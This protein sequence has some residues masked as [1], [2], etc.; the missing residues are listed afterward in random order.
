MTLL[1]AAWLAAALS[2]CALKPVSRAD[3]AM[4][5]IVSFTVYGGSEE[6]LDECVALC[7][8]YEGLW[9]RTIETSDIFRLNDAGGEPVA[10]SPDTAELIANAKRYCADSGG[11]LDVTIGGVSALWDFNKQV[12][13]EK[14]EILKRLPSVDYRNIGVEG[15]TVTL[16]NGAELDLG[17]VAKGTVADKLAVFLRER[18]IKSAIINLGGNVYALGCR[19][20][21]KPF[22]V[23]IRSPFDENELLGTIGL[24]DTS[25]VTSGVYER[26]FVKDGR[27]YHHL[28][29]PKTGFPV[30]NGLVSV[31]IIDKT[32]EKAD[33]LSTACF[34]LGLTD[35]MALARKEGVE[36]IFVTSDGSLH[37]TGG[38][39]ALGFKKAGGNGN[40]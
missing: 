31:S 36:A 11:A 22:N 2:G 3:F 29:D 38:I 39:D 9:S 16:R 13:P 15:N 18:G 25:V 1:A 37:K 14:A 10:V 26:G 19:P 17:A 35:G 8:S 32:S 6:L 24:A 12:S 23:G 30:D 28:L 4:S 40:R 7:Q 27:L 5:T 21:G 20:D 33:A 34:V